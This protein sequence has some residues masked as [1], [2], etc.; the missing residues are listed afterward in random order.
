[1]FKI[2]ISINNVTSSENKK[3]SVSASVYVHIGCKGKKNLS[4]CQIYAISFIIRTL[5]L[6]IPTDRYVK[7]IKIKGRKLAPFK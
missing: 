5:R 1:M 4:F 3:T 7:I 2:R 6:N